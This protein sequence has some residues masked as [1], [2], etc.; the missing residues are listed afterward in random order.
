MLYIGGLIRG[1]QG[2]IISPFLANPGDQPLASGMGI[3][4]LHEHILLPFKIGVDF[5]RRRPGGRA[6]ELEHEHVGLVLV[7]LGFEPPT[8]TD[9]PVSGMTQ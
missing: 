7:L 2:E 1:L 9:Q 8:P 5:H 3:A 6:R 4:F